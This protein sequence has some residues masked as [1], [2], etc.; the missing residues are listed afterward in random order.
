MSPTLTK[1]RIHKSVIPPNEFLIPPQEYFC[2]PATVHHKTFA[3]FK[4][5]APS[6]VKMESASGPSVAPTPPPSPPKRRSSRNNTTL[7]LISTMRVKTD[8]NSTCKRHETCFTSGSSVDRSKVNYLRDKI[9]CKLTPG[10]KRK[11]DS[12]SK[13]SVVK[14]I[15]ASP[16]LR[17]R[18]SSTLS[19]SRDPKTSARRVQSS[20]RISAGKPQ[21]KGLYKSGSTGSMISKKSSTESL[22]SRP[23][24]PVKTFGSEKRKFDLALPLLSPK[25]KLVKTK[26]DELLSPTEVK[27]GI[28]NISKCNAQYKESLAPLRDQKSLPIKIG[29]T[30]KGKQM[31]KSSIKRALLSPKTSRITIGQKGRSSTESLNAPKKKTLGSSTQFKAR[32]LQ[33][34]TKKDQINGT[35]KQNTADQKCLSKATGAEV[36]KKLAT[37]PQMHTL[38]S[39]HFFRSLFLRNMKPSASFTL[40]KNSWLIEKTNQLTRR[41]ASLSE[42]SIGAM[43]IYLQHTKPVSDSRFISLDVIRSRSASP[44]SVTFSEN[45]STQGNSKRSKSLPSKMVLSQTSRPV[46]PVLAARGPSPILKPFGIDREPYRS[47]GQSPS[48]PRKLTF[49]QPSRPKSPILKQPLKGRSPSPPTKMFFSETTRPISPDVRRKHSPPASPRVPRSPSCRKIMQFKNQQEHNKPQDLTLYTCPDLNHSTTSLDSFRSEDYQVYLKDLVYGDRNE[50]FKELNQFYSDIEKVGQLEQKF[51]LKPRGKDE[52]E[53]IDYD[54][55]MEVRSRE[56]AEH[57][58]QHLYHHLKTHEKEKGFLFLPKDVRQYKW[59]LETDRGLRIKEKSVENLKEEFEKLRCEESQLESARRREMDYKKDT[60]KPLWRGTS[61][62]N[63]ASILSEKRSQSEGR[64]KSA[65]HKLSDHGIGSRIWSSLSMEQV[66]N[67]KKQLQ[68]IYGEEPSPSEDSCSKGYE[69][70]VSS[71]AE[72]PYIP[73]LTVRRNSDSSKHD[74]MSEDEKRMISHTLSKEVLEKVAKRRREDKLA[75]P[76]VKGK[77]TMG[78]IATQ[79]AH[80]KAVPKEPTKPLEKLVE[81][82]K[83]STSETESAST[84]DSA[85]TVINLQDVQKKVEYFEKAKDIETY[86]PTVYRP[87]E[88]GDEEPTSPPEEIK[89]AEQAPK[90]IHPSKSCQSLKEFFGQTELVKFATL[91]LAATRKSECNY[92]KKPR[93]R[94]LDISPIRT[95]SEAN[96][97]DSLSRSRS[98]SPYY[99]E[100]QALAKRGEVK[101]LRKQFEF[102]EDF[103]GEKKLKRSRSENDLKVYGHVDDLRR[104]YEYPIHSGRGRSRVKRGGMVSP[105]WLKAEDRYMPHI[106]IISKIAS[107]YSFS[108]HKT[109]K[110]ASKSMEEL[111]EILGCPVGEVSTYKSN[112]VSL[113]G[114][115]KNYILQKRSLAKWMHLKFRS[116]S[117]CKKARLTFP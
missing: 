90:T 42:P 96:S 18:I 71:Q 116:T 66:N 105:V 36:A 29:I 17:S 51:S 33:P 8:K 9:T 58:L 30:D 98:A 97:T 48:P 49:T 76:L 6:N 35:L 2:Y 113:L 38:E 52:N 28:T 93:L 37:S 81:S 94:A 102:F 109:N 56:K 54:R 63:L 62:M 108:K 78:A 69:V 44:K 60:Y 77:E 84:D 10:G 79:E 14:S 80:I 74:L 59:K 111:A 3:N 25:S 5:T 61:V 53:I 70:E 50:K 47:S 19:S 4:Q 34:K 100:A 16:D 20:T 41:R 82:V 23:S 101:K 85:Q 73:H 11:G 92:T 65:R 64:V 45:V 75:L 46:T 27:K 21:Q 40:P 114:C 68:D 95:I 103:F 55:W 115:T 99:E 67:L 12:N 86:V 32:K 57:E 26:S 89:P 7:R 104:K 107:L 91:P 88:D 87:A 31:L 13:L 22:S 39:N 106:N 83:N 15:S 110:E 72:K 24:T 117:G 112:T 43:Q 1:I